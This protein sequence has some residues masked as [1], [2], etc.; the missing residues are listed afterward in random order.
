[1]K[2]LLSLLTSI[3][4]TNILLG[5]FILLLIAGAIL[6]PEKPSFQRINQMSLFSWLKEAPL[7]DSWWLYEAIAILGLL[8]LNTIFCSID[9]LLRK[10][11]G[12]NLLLIISPQIIHLGFCFIMIAHL[13]S[14]AYSFHLFWVFTEKGY[15]RLPDGTMLQL[16]RID[17]STEKGY[18]TSMKAVFKIKGDVE[19][20]VSIGPNK[21]A[22]ISG[23]G[24][25]LKQISLNPVPMALVEISYEPGAMWALI[26][27][28]L[29]FVGTVLLV[30]LRLRYSH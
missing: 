19:K 3:R 12:R 9:S 5:L 8:V 29:F 22:L 1:M 2:K 20:T 15:S 13:V 27:G 11:Q 21:P 23:V 7:S 6:M 17:Y 30:A 25:Y 24:V 18:F 4:T 28:V 16:D 26:G 10:R 14:S